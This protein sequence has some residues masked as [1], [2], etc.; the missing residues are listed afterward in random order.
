LIRDYKWKEIADDAAAMRYFNAQLHWLEK[1]KSWGYYTVDEGKWF[2]H[3]FSPL[4]LQRA[5]ELLAAC[6]NKMIIMVGDIPSP[7]C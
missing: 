1:S 2:A 5:G 3:H 6:T 7:L 4:T